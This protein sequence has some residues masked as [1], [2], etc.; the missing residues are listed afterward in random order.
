MYLKVQTYKE[1]QKDCNMDLETLGPW[2]RMPKIS[3]DTEWFDIFPY[4]LTQLLSSTKYAL[5]Y[6]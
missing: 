4:Q 5:D 6:L 1:K 2:P 3:Q